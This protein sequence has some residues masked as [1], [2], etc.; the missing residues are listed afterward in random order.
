MSSS[1]RDVLW[2][3]RF[4]PP[5]EGY[6]LVHVYQFRNEPRH[7]Y[8]WEHYSRKGGEICCCT[9][10]EEGPDSVCEFFTKKK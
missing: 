8:Y 4:A 6:V 1:W 7:F 2:T 3:D 9:S 5:E 10:P